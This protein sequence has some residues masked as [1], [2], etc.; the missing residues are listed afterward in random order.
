VDL[1]HA[2]S[3]HTAATIASPLSMAATACLLTYRR[4]LATR[5]ALNCAAVQICLST[6]RTALVCLLSFWSL[7]LPRAA[8]RQHCRPVECGKEKDQISVG[9]PCK[10]AWCYLMRLHRNFAAVCLLHNAKRCMTTGS[11]KRMHKVQA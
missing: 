11:N 9:E 10:H 3:V 4:L 8:L 6:P 7:C 5:T 2:S 1:N